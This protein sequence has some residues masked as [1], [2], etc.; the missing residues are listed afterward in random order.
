MT[1]DK[2]KLDLNAPAFGHGSQKVDEQGNLEVK[3]I[4]PIEEAKPVE[5]SVEPAE[6]K[7]EEER[8]EPSVE[9]NKVPYSRF[10]KFHDAARE[11]EKEAGFYKAEVD[12]L[13]SIQ[14]EKTSPDEVP[15]YFKKLYGDETS[16]NWSAVQ[17]AW[18]IEQQRQE[19]IFRQATEKAVE[20]VRSERIQEEE[21][22][23]ENVE[24][25]DN[26]EI[27]LEEFLGRKLTEKESSAILDITDEYT[28]K[29]DDGN[30]LGALLPEDKA[31]EIYQLKQKLAEA[32]KKESRD[33]VAALSGSQTQGETSVAVDKDKNFNP[34]DWNAY[35]KRL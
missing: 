25:L 4:E 8:V 35:K 29:D 7:K 33:N 22:Q 34:L 15:D 9:D 14:V 21:R 24:E 6:I 16:S 5:P 26:R 31:W 3:L 11:A 10:K 20:A 13:K 32:P 2:T 1:L 19:N 30:Y 28:P 18:K 27:R 17:D 12:R 23:N